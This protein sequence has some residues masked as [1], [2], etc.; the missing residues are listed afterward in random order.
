MITFKETQDTVL[1]KFNLNPDELTEAP[2][3]LSLVKQFINDSQQQVYERQM[4]WMRKEGKISIKAKYNTGNIAVTNG[5]ATIT[6]TTTTWTLAM[7]GQKII[8]SS[9]AYRIASFTSATS[10]TLDT[11]YIGTTAS[12]LSYA[13]YYDTYLM[14]ID[15]KTLIDI[16][17]KNM[18]EFDYLDFEDERDERMSTSTTTNTPTAIKLLHRDSALYSTGTVSTTDG[19]ATITGSGTI[20]D[21]SLIGHYIQIGNYGRTY[22]I[23][24]VASATSLT[25]E[26][27][28]GNG[29]LSTQ[30]YKIDPPGLHLLRFYDSPETAKI[31]PYT[32]WPRDI[33]LYDNDDMS[34]IPSDSVLSLGGIWRYS[35]AD[36]TLIRVSNISADRSKIDFEDEIRRLTGRGLVETQ[37]DKVQYRDV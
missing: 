2:Q 20:W 15:F 6:G 16:G 34:P 32:Y 18:N 10:L 12:G 35:K 5:S 31:I 28:F 14:P 3:V 36:D 1:R 27:N 37:G 30:N 8:I 29:T 33:K 4:L 9:V 21:N 24:A 13:I 7:V 26:K 23:T 17:A 25:I 19:S 11:E 22:K